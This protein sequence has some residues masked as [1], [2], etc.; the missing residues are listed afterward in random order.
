[1]TTA[2]KVF[3]VIIIINTLIAIA[4]FIWGNIVQSF[5]EKEK[6]PEGPSEEK[7]IEIVSEAAGE[8]ESGEEGAEE[9][10]KEEPYEWRL[11]RTGYLFKA[12]VI[13]LCPVVGILFFLVTQL[14]YVLFFRTK[15]DL[16]DVIFG[17]DKVVANRKADEDSERNRV[18]IEEALAVADK[19]SLRSLVMDVV[20]GDVHKSLA[21]ISLALNSEDT[22]TSHYAASVLRD[23]LN[24]FRQ[25]SQELYNA[26]HRGDE[27][28][29][30]YACTMIEY[31]NEVLRQDVFPDMEQRAFVEMMEEACDWLYKSEENRHRLACEYIEWIAARLL[32]TGQYDHMKVWCDRSMEMYP[33]ELSSYTI[34]LKLYFSIQDKENFFGVMNRLKQSDI[35]IDRDTLDLIRVFS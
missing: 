20:K 32:A 22:E 19:D 31:M 24:D 13:F 25:E 10:E 28:A 29:A 2:E 34:Q 15:A 1:M 11:S 4:Y 27:N 33:E 5:R 9:E 35:V 12:L 23:A 6:P 7:K 8:E 26:L 16:T 17:K 18:P 30:D 14:M 3:I 21:T